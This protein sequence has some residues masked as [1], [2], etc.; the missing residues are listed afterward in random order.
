MMNDTLAAALSNINNAEKV[1]KNQCTAKPV[2]KM[3]KKILDI[4]KDHNYVGSY[5]VI[6]DNKGGIVKINILGA[7]NN[8]QAIKPRFSVQT[9]TYEKFEK[10]YLPAKDFGLLIVSTSKGVMTHHE[11]KEKKIGG[12]LLAYVY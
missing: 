4:M 7:I 5:E 2:S 12:K 3:L 9:T 1:G 11:A 10:R 6:E 8:C